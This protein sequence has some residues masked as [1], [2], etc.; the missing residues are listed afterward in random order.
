MH[1]AYREKVAARKCSL[2]IRLIFWS[3]NNSKSNCFIHREL[4]LLSFLITAIKNC[5]AIKSWLCFFIAIFS[6]CSNHNRFC[7][8]FFVKFNRLID[9]F[10]M[11]IRVHVLSHVVNQTA[12]E[13]YDSFCLSAARFNARLLECKQRCTVSTSVSRI[14]SW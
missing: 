13:Y 8:F 10:G 4:E 6:K 14:N 11:F 2:F 1:Y 3:S 9:V 12:N 5:I 7:Q